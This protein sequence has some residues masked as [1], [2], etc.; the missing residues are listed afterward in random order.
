MKRLIISMILCM[1]LALPVAAQKKTDREH[2][3]FIG[4]V[5]SAKVETA[6]LEE[7]SGKL[8]EK[9]RELWQ[10]LSFDANGN[11]VER[12][13]RDHQSS[14]LDRHVYSYDAS[15]N[16]AEKF[17]PTGMPGP[18]L[19]PSGK[20]LSPDGTIEAT[21]KFEYDK[22]GNRIE[23]TAYWRTG[24]LWFKE[25]YTYDS[26]S[27]RIEKRHYSMDGLRYRQV[28][29]YDG[30]G[31]LS[32]MT[33]YKPNG[34]IARKESYNYEF[35]SKGNW[36]KRITAEWKEK[37]SAFEPKEATY[38]T[39]I[40]DDGAGSPPTAGDVTP[41]AAA[42]ASVQPQGSQGNFGATQLNKPLGGEALVR[43]QPK[44]SLAGR[45]VGGTV[46]VEVMIDEAG[47]VVTA[48]P[49]NVTIRKPRGMTEA[50]ARYCGEELKK[51]ALDAAMQWKFHP[52][53]V[54]GSPVKAVGNITFSFHQ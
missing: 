16:R 48:K 45:N 4:P 26:L 13:D 6:K 36:V 50:D 47:N 31:K 12:L 14:G 24:E 41:Q 3:G 40:Y 46:V 23:E 43:V 39:I 21:W 27:H 17:Y 7:K 19:S 10:S 32:E 9:R 38:R 11:L 2:E 54:N 1:V 22:Q 34:S 33:E 42:V 8:E 25:V 30:D 18:A 44:Y 49:V 20:V 53:K 51:A 15:G 5:R 29:T 28:Y 37:A 35:D 52:V